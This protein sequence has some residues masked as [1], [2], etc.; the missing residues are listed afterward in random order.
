MP[1]RHRTLGM[2]ALNCWRHGCNAPR[3]TGTGFQ[4]ESRPLPP[5]PPPGQHPELLLLRS[6]PFRS[7]TRPRGPPPPRPG[8]HLPSGDHRRPRRHAPPS[9]VP[10]NGSG[11]RYVTKGALASRQPMGAGR[12]A[13]PRGAAVIPA[14]PP[15]PLGGERRPRSR[16][17]PGPG[18]AAGPWPSRG[19]E[20]KFAA[21][22][23][24]LEQPPGT[25][26]RC[27]CWS[28]VTS[29]ALE[30]LVAT[31]GCFLLSHNRPRRGWAVRWQPPHLPG[32][33]RA[34][35]GV[36]NDLKMVLHEQWLHV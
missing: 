10:A 33:Y 14:P 9:R 15:P 16:P 24:G 4:R 27:G 5:R 19:R 26:G 12:G 34:V 25:V 18:P 17:G 11:G 6:A 30:E 3:V 22:P 36:E 32:R 23:R 1:R 35:S 29:T 31:W 7:P 20:G 2:P 13:G 8:P 21:C 28:S